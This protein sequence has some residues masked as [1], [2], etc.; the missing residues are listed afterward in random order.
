M[1]TEI[2]FYW[3]LCLCS[4]VKKLAGLCSYSTNP[5]NNWAFL[6]M[7][8]FEVERNLICQETETSNTIVI[9]GLEYQ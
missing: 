7:I 1:S 2:G 8:Y 3:V 9:S 4:Q 5:F 6:E